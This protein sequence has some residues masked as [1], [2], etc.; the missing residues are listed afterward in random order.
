MGLILMGLKW[1]F[2]GIFSILSKIP[3][4]GWLFIVL[5]AFG[6]W[7]YRAASQLKAAA[8]QAKLAAAQQ[9]IVLEQ[10]N[11]QLEQDAN[12]HLNHV[13]DDLIRSQANIAAQRRADDKRLRDVAAAYLASADAATKAAASTC[14]SLDA[15]AVAILPEQTVNDLEQLATDADIVSSR[16]VACQS[17][18]T[19]VV[20]PLFKGVPDPKVMESGP[21][22]T[23]PP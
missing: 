23:S 13:Q 18:I 1:C 20:I 17:Y 19:T 2:G 6:W 7:E 3:P 5:V 14:R 11:R 16:L 21:L 10:Q 4:L 12:V 9:Q 15:P 8:E 22:A